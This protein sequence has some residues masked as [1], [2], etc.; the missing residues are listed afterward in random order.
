VTLDVGQE[1]G[2]LLTYGSGRPCN[3]LHARWLGLVRGSHVALEGLTDD[4]AYRGVLRKGELT[5]ALIG[6]FIEH[7]MQMPAQA[8]W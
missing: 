5:D 7:N 1:P 2:F 3:A 8:R 6:C 4:V